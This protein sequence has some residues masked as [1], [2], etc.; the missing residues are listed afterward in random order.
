MVTGQQGRRKC[1]Q[2]GGGGQ[3]QDSMACN[4]P[5]LIEYEKLIEYLSSGAPPR[6][7]EHYVHTRSYP[8]SVCE[9]QLFV[10]RGDPAKTPRVG[11][12]PHHDFCLTDMNT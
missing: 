1:V 10:G 4:Y 11:K 6:P 2:V 8:A 5:Q 3:G 9:G 7:D 12:T